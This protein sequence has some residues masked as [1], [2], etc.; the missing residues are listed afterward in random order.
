MDPEVHPDPHTF[1]YDR[2]VNPKKQFYRYG[3]KLK[4]YIMP[5]GAG[6]SICP[7]RSFAINEMKIFVILMF[8]Y[9]DME[10]V[11][12]EEEIPPV[13]ESSYGFGTVKPSHD[14]QFKYQ[15]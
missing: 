7:E 10:L 2:F 5:F 12:P 1:K 14:I 3:G 6:H 4:Q 13:E 11:N 15:L 8:T 9:F